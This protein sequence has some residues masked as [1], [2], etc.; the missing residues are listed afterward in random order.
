MKGAMIDQ[1]EPY[2]THLKKIFHTISHI[3]KNYN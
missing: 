1:G 3:E 2:F